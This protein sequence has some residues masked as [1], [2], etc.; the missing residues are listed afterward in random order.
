MEDLKDGQEQEIAERAPEAA[1]AAPTSEPEE[2]MTGKIE[3]L[4]QENQKV[5]E[6]VLRLAAEFDNYRKRTEREFAAIRQNATAE[7]LASLLPV[8][9]DL[10]R[11]M[12]ASQESQDF[13]ALWEALKLVHKNFTKVLLDAGLK[14]MQSIDQPFDPEKH[15]ALLH[16]PVPGKEANLV[17]EEHKKGYEFRDRVLRHAQVIVSK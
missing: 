13:A 17:V 1:S 7:L 14:P 3:E 16:V 12:N 9:D 11:V 6:Q 2:P 4:L 15:D 8:V 10:D 5:R